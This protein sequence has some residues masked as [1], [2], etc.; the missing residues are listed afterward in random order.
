MPGKP[1]FCQVPGQVAT[2]RVGPAQEEKA[3][4]LEE[5]G[6]EKQGTGQLGVQG[7]MKVREEGG[8]FEV[9]GCESEAVS[10][11]GPQIMRPPLLCLSL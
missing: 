3:F 5:Q 4:L 7:F 10:W 2:G 8:G 6:S 1:P 9:V 11:R